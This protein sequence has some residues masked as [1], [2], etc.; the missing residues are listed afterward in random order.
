VRVVDLP[1]PSEPGLFPNYK[2]SEYCKSVVRLPF[3]VRTF[4]RTRGDALGK[5][6]VMA[7]ANGDAQ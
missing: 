6:N 4:E 3:P 2:Q 1:I 7:D 5:I